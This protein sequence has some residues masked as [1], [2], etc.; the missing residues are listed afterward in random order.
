MTTHGPGGTHPLALVED[1]ETIVR[2]EKELFAPHADVSQDEG[3]RASA[4][5]S[6]SMFGNHFT[7][8]PTDE[9]ARSF[10]AKRRSAFFGPLPAFITASLSFTAVFV[11]AGV[12]SPMFLQYQQQWH[13]PTWMATLAFGAYALALLAALLWT[14]SLSDLVGRRPVIAGALVIQLASMLTFALAPNIGWVIV[15]RVLQGVA[16]GVVTGPFTAA[17]IELAPPGRTRLAEIVAAI[18][19]AVGLGVGSLSAGIAIETTPNSVSVVFGTL[20]ALMALGAFAIVLSPETVRTPTT[21][22]VRPVRTRISVSPP[23]RAEYRA[24]IPALVG[25]WMHG[26]L[27][28]GLAP[29]I[30]R[31]VFGLDSG[32]I[33]GATIFA[34][35]AMT[36]VAAL[37]LSRV[38][39]RVAVAGGSAAIVGAAVVIG[40]AILSQQF[41]LLLLG[42]LIGGAGFGAG[43]SAIMRMIN[44]LIDTAHRATTSA[45]IYIVAYLSFGLP[46]IIAGAFIT[47]AGIRATA[48]V[49][50]ALTAAAALIG[51][52]TQLLRR[53]RRVSPMLQGSSAS[54]P[55]VHVNR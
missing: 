14:G 44:G 28:L 39:A 25:I 10:T 19:G 23:A 26:G 51:C 47:T 32:P 2:L 50:A 21:S 55:L 30:V 20:A 6:R 38:N 5:S 45:A 36:A 54:S 16:T 15:A 22:A 52:A 13:F 7:D 34:S 11:A 37:L 18:A 17:I 42:G 31:D 4:Q 48:T 8:Q 46:S 12:P 27:F 3:S 43:F 33:I 49:Y 35:M 53:R 9:S 1:N 29:L 24:A 40:A 41:M